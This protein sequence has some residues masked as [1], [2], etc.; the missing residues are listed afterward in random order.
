MSKNRK[1]YTMKFSSSR[2][3]EFSYTIEKLTFQKAKQ[4][5]EIIGLADNQILRSIRDIQN[6]Y[7]D[8]QQ[9]D[10][11]YMK[12]DALKYAP[13]SSDVETELDELQKQIDYLTF[14]PEYITIVMDHS[15]HYEHL[16][17]NGLLL[18]EKKYIR[19]SCSASQARTSTVV[20]CEETIFEQLSRRL[21]NGRNVNQPL[22][23][24]KFNAYFGVAGS[25]TSLVSTPTF[26]LVPDFHSEKQFMVNYITETN[27]DEDDRVDIRSITEMFNRFDG[28]GLISIRQAQ[29]W[30]QELG[31]DYVPAQWCIR[32]N[33]IKGMLCTFDIHKFCHEINNGEYK[34]KTSYKDEFGGNKMVDLRDI[35]VILSESQFKLWDS[36]E[37][38]EDYIKN[39][40]QHKLHWGVSLFTPKHDKNILKLNYQFLQTLNLTKDDIKAVSNKFIDWIQS[41]TLE[42][43]ESSLLFLLGENINETNIAYVLGESRTQWVKALLWDHRLIQDK[44][45]QQKIYDLIKAKIQRACLG[46]IIVDGNFQVIVSDPYAQMEHICGLPVNGLLSEKEY[47]SSYW[48]K[49][50]VT[51]VNSMRAPLTY[52]SEHVKLTLAANDKLHNWYQHCYTGII[53]NVH[54][55]E[56]VN[57]S[58]SDFDY[59]IIATTSDQTIINGIFENELPVVYQAPK[60]VQK[61]ITPKDLYAADLFSFGSQI[62]AITNKSTSGYALLSLYPESSEEYTTLLNRLKMCT[63]LQSAQI[64]KAKIGREV[65]GIPKTWVKYNKISDEDTGLLK[66]HKLLLNNTLLDK[67]PYFF[68]FLYEDTRKLYTQH[69][70]KHNL[71]CMRKFNTSID[72]LIAKPEKSVL[73]R[74]FIHTYNEFMPVIDSDSVMNNLCKYI[75]SIHFEVK[76]RLK[77]DSDNPIH[78]LYMNEHSQW[79][80]REYSIVIKKYEEG[81][82]STAASAKAGLATK[83]T[84]LTKNEP[85]HLL[86]AKYDWIESNLNSLSVPLDRIVNY[87]IHYLYVEKSKLSKDILWTIYGDVIVQN[88][89][90]RA[91]GNVAI[92]IKTENGS[93]QYLGEHYEF[94]VIQYEAN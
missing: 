56:T 54:G 57:W 41:I 21:N 53:V 94:K 81:I 17:Y 48:N 23:P 88:I 19:F 68:I 84:K 27:K 6:R 12:R 15:K 24:S 10:T 87:L 28:Q 65:K 35:D 18:N 47:F 4:F 3:K 77:A 58:G 62:G 55:H 89:K 14:I 8:L 73:E 71:S 80:Q 36:F 11:L 91:N 82:K 63:K 85:N 44:Y 72:E 50:N 39:C 66:H 16:F 38:I 31:L 7:V 70:K 22:T 2:L 26:C 49:R 78:T 67:H 1:F 64:D 9:L 79:L 29:K 83:T 37:S 92:P 86:R 74:Q 76:K 20:F 90:T 42:N 69:Y 45:I 61:I 46:E 60:S 5:G 25:A 43:V 93:I 75:D 33:F 30:A 32:Q 13:P 34:I 59:D 51:V 52:R 40:E